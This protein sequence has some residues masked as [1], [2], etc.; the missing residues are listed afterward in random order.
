MYAWPIGSAR[1]LSR[2]AFNWPSRYSACWPAS[3]GKAGEMLSPLGPWHE[4]QT[5]VASLRASDS[6]AD[7]EGA[8]Q[9]IVSSATGIKRFLFMSISRFRGLET[10]PAE[11]IK[12]VIV[13][14]V[15]AVT[16]VVL[17]RAVEL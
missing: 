9:E 17:A 11:Q 4:A 13:A 10:Q 1:V 16:V 5:S 3:R 7:A 12:R 6:W 14:R 2:K 8:M 15:P